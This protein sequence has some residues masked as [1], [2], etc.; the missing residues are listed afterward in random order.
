MGWPSSMP[1]HTQRV[2]SLLERLLRSVD[3]VS[4]AGEAVK[5]LEKGS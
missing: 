5:E 4:V 1:L 2:L 3:G